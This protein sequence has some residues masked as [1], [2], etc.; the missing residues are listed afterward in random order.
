MDKPA[1]LSGHRTSRKVGA[2]RRWSSSAA[3]ALPVFACFLGGATEKWAEGFV[4]ALLGI[5]LL[6]SPPRFSLGR[7]ANLILL[8]LIACALIAFLPARWFAEADWRIALVNDFRVTLPATLTP[9]PWVTL[10]CLLS[11]LAM[12]AWL[13]YVCGSDWEPREVRYELRFFATGVVF[14]GAVCIA[15]YLV[16]TAPPFWHN[17]RGFG[18]FPN[19]NQ[20]A[21]LLAITAVVVIACGA[22]DI[23]NGKKRWIVWGVALLIL[24]AA[25]VLNF[26]R[27]GILLLIAGAAI[28]LGTAALQK[29]STARLGLGL[30]LL[31]VLLTI[32]LIFG[33]E[34]LER[35]HL[36]DD[37]S[38]AS[39]DFRWLIFRDALQLIRSSPWCGIGLGNFE[40]VFAIFRVASGGDTRAHHPESDWLWLWAEMGLPALLLVIGGSVFFLRR[41]FPAAEARNYRF[42]LAAFVAAVLFG[43]HGLFD[44]SAHRVGTGLAGIFLLGLAIRRPLTLRRSRLVPVV[45]RI[46][47]VVLI[48]IGAAWTVAVRSQ[49]AL[50]GSV[51]AENNR[52]RATIANRGRNFPEAMS[53]ATRALAW[54][55][56][57]WQLY[58]VRAIAAVN[59]RLPQQALDD[60]RRARFL[61]PNAYEVA[62]EEGGVWLTYQPKLALTAWRESLRRAGSRR[63]EVYGRMIGMA[64]KF[65]PAL[66]PALEN[67]GRTHAELIVKFLEW[68]RGEKFN[69]ALQRLLDDDPELKSLGPADRA[70]LFAL[71]I[72]RGNV[73]KLNAAV[74]EHPDW[75]PIAWRAVAKFR[76]QQQDFRGATELAQRFGPHP[77][78][79]QISTGG[80]DLARTLA[81]QPDNYAVGFALY[82]QQKEQ[83]NFDGALDTV[84]HFTAQKSSPAYFHFLEAECWAA[85]ENWERAWAAWQ[86]YDAAQLR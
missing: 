47:G 78:L 48:A 3:A 63:A 37:G 39:A 7:V 44:V 86:S 58:F 6:T 43:L 33:G 74:D 13:Y 45:C 11:F 42:R 25:V 49:L 66:L 16:H 72:E 40:P 75:L 15:L 22:D 38:T 12:I 31:L 61:E 80:V 4:V 23:R 5:L 81:A 17:E 69:T 76:S 30:S 26:S 83:R 54:T 1:E 34:T 41:G 50:P 68:Q 36:R 82:Q 62:F 28:W 79:P 35:F 51:G 19:R 27:A 32:F 8:A 10:Q 2:N 59:E 73:A 65:N 46:S 67:L 70:N 71:W 55:P 52:T 85:K 20:T 14:L 24:I 18:P 84:R 21:D 64:E 60:F 53:Q 77:A 57:D 56:L 9:Q 29:R